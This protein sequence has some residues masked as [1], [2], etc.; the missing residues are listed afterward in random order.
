MI[1]ILSLILN[2]A[3]GDGELSREAQILVS[4]DS[5]NFPDARITAVNSFYQAKTIDGKTHA[6]L[7]QMIYG[8]RTNIAIAKVLFEAGHI[9][10]FE[11]AKR[12]FMREVV[13][14][15]HS[16][17]TGL[18][19]I[20]NFLLEY[21]ARKGDPE[22]RYEVAR[23]IWWGLEN[24]KHLNV[25]MALLNFPPDILENK[26][27][28]SGTAQLNGLLFQFLIKELEK[29]EWDTFLPVLKRLVRLDR[30]TFVNYFE[31]FLESSES[32]GIDQTKKLIDAIMTIAAN[33][34]IRADVRRILQQQL[35]SLPTELRT[36]VWAHLRELAPKNQFFNSSVPPYTKPKGTVVS[37][38]S[39]VCSKLFD[40]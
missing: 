22:D 12:L 16:V 37:F 40:L 8:G 32:R 38:N 20:E 33:S 23:L 39:R 25:K 2:L 7:Q 28:H 30:T 13:A 1:L 6:K 4:P 29:F 35:N 9:E 19:E 31:A 18:E 26:T 10:A 14:P 11:I 34:G 17:I 36:A 27:A 21:S 24:A 3:W 5:L 15:T